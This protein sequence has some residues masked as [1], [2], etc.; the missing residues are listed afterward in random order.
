MGLLRH[1]EREELCPLPSR[2]LIGRGPACSLRLEQPEVSGE[3]ATLLWLR[4]GWHVRDLGSRNGTFV[5]GSRMETGESKPLVLGAKLSFGSA[6]PEWELVDAGPPVAMAQCVE[7]AELR[8]VVDGVLVLPRPACPMWTIYC[9]L[10]GEWVAEG[11]EGE[12]Q[13]LSAGTVLPVDE[14]S[15][16]I[17]LPEGVA[18]TATVGVGPELET[19]TFSFRVS[20]D[21]EHVSLTVEHQGKRIEL[22]SREHQY[23]LLTLARARLEDAEEPAAEQGWIERDR[24]TRML[25]IDGNALNVAIFRARSQLGAA[26]VGGA[27]GIVEVRRG[28]RRIGVE[29]NRLNVGAL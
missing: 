26:G 10:R 18:R 1:C 21:E 15:W 20:R 7:T 29:P 9:T 13:V 12:Q 27:A 6:A 14:Q 19:S 23:M 28:Q 24:L 16:R 22:E 2:L 5:D 11:A 4:G 25:G 8:P 17:W 3:H